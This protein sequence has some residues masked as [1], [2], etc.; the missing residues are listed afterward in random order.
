MLTFQVV[1]GEFQELP[2]LK[3]STDLSLSKVQIGGADSCGSETKIW[4]VKIF[5]QQ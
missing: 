3:R 4:N 2:R 5:L 1:D